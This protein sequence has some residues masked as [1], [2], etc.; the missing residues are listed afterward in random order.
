VRIDGRHIG[1]A[2][3]LPV[4]G[5]LEW[6]RGLSVP[7]EVK[8]RIFPELENRLAMLDELGSAT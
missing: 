4:R 7:P 8:E 6:L 3:A 1:E 2:A 5:A